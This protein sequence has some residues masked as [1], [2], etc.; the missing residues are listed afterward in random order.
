MEERRR[1]L[2]FEGPALRSL[3]DPWLGYAL[4]EGLDAEGVSRRAL[5]RSVLIPVD[6]LTTEMGKDVAPLVEALTDWESRSAADRE[7][8][9]QGNV[10]AIEATSPLVFEQRHGAPGRFLATGLV[11]SEA[12]VHLAASLRAK[13]GG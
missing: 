11:A 6:D 8:R 7:A 1:A 3:L 12:R 13:G 9:R 2:A 5:V 10:N 4:I